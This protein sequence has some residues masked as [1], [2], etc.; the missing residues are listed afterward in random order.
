MKK[1]TTVALLGVFALPTVTLAAA[2]KSPVRF[3]VEYGI[4]LYSD[5]ETKF[6]ESG[7]PD[8]KSRASAFNDSGAVSVGVDINGVQLSIMPRYAKIDDV[9]VTAIWLNAVVPLIYDVQALNGIIPYVTA[10]AGWIRFSEDYLDIDESTFGYAI[11]AGIRYWFNDNVFITG[12]VGYETMKFKNIN[13]SPLSM[14][15]SG[16]GLRTSLGYRF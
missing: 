11:G 2:D 5:S 6:K 8:E 3:F 13:G 9:S 14:E 7:F 16:F 10:S 15:V 12:G 1:I 4:G